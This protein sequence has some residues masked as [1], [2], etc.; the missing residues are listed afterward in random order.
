[1]RA[2]VNGESYV[3]CDGKGNVE[4][5][6]NLIHHETFTY[7]NGKVY[8]F[9]R[10]VTDEDYA[11]KVLSGMEEGKQIYQKIAAELKKN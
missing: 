9:K 10:E 1:M 6:E 7:F 4:W 2:I 11:K 8:G 5:E 3:M